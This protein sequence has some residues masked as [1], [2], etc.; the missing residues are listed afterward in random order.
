[1]L[2]AA[3]VMAS[4]VIVFSSAQ[5]SPECIAAYNATF[6]SFDALACANA[7]FSLFRSDSE[8]DEQ[9]MMVCNETQQCNAMVQ[10]VIN[11]CGNTVS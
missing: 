11:V 3:V 10:N 2:I 8:N 4:S 7:Y 9:R 6:R 1:M 5:P